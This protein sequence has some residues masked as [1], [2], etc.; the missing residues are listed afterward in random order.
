MKD[1]WWGL[2][3]DGP[4]CDGGIILDPLPRYVLNLALGVT[5]KAYRMTVSA[6]L[7]SPTFTRLEAGLV[8]LPPAL[9]P[10]SGVSVRGVVS[11][12]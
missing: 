6:L 12:Q 5:K 8:L 10:V 1:P 7:F 9:M 11:G 4:I 3:I 2:R